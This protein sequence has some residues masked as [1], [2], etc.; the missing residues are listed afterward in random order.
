MEYSELSLEELLNYMH[1]NKA[2]YWIG[3]A[4]WAERNDFCNAAK[5]LTKTMNAP[6]NE[7]ADTATQQLGMLHFGLFPIPDASKKEALRLFE[8]SI[9]LLVSKLYAGFLYY[10][11]TDDNSKPD[12]EM[13]L[14]GIRLIEEVIQRLIKDDGNDDY[15]DAHE[16]L[17]IGRIYAKEGLFTNA[18]AEEYLGKTIV[19]ATCN[20]SSDLIEEAE[21]I[22]QNL[23]RWREFINRMEE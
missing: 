20:N 2:W 12:R 23:R 15:L 6:D 4:Y 10:E 7:W 17:R 13:Q 1:D 19:K 8:K 3:M 18:K 5:Y 21:E 11:G 16:Y 14:K 22:M 9:S